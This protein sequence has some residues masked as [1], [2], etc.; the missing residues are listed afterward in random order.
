MAEMEGIKR[1]AEEEQVDDYRDH[2]ELKLN[3]DITLD[4]PELLTIYA[5]VYWAKESNG[6]H[7]N[8]S[9]IREMIGHAMLKFDD[10]KYE[11]FDLKYLLETFQDINHETTKGVKVRAEEVKDHLVKRIKK[12][13]SSPSLATH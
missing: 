1:E 3:E 7:W 5:C 13:E 6:R 4:Q 12:S 8:E 2:L 9:E 10:D 11:K